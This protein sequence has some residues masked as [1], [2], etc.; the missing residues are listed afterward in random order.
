ME[1]FIKSIITIIIIIFCIYSI[2]WLW[3]KQIDLKGTAKKNLT[4]PITNFQNLF[5]MVDENAIYQN[6]KIVGTIEGGVKETNEK[7]FFKIIINTT[8]LDQNKPLQYKRT[9][10]KINKVN[11]SNT[12][13]LSGI[14]S[15]S[16]TG[17]ECQKIN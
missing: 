15:S 14:E 1:T 10:C 12:T 3:S 6:G 11:M 9:K 17:V 13:K 5:E 16:L 8:K 7:I 2:I 4:A